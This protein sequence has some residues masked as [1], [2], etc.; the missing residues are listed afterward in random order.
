MDWAAT[1]PAIVTGAVGVAGIVG[2]LASARITRTSAANNL[3]LSITA[4]DTRQR[5][6]EKRQIYAAYLGSINQ[7]INAIG[8]EET[9]AAAELL[10]SV[11]KKIMGLTISYA[12]A[13]AEA[14]QALTTMINA[15]AELELVAPPEV[16]KQSVKVRQLIA[17][18]Y[19][20]SDK[21]EQAPIWK[22][23]ATELAD[24]HRVM[25]ADLDGSPG[26]E[27]EPH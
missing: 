19:Q 21:N 11:T 1:T 14:Q 16:V 10:P 22:S 6:A 15:Q 4:E 26:I 27:I 17:T 20:K 18:W 8:Q 13:Q 7:A 9:A 3:R 2:T 23:L 25:R 12:T 24:L 5:R